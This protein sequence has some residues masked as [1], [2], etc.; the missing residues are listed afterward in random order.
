MSPAMLSFSSSQVGFVNTHTHARL[1]RAV[2]LHKIQ[3]LATV[4]H[5]VMEL[6]LCVRSRLKEIK[7]KS[8]VLIFDLVFPPLLFFFRLQTLLC[9]LR[10]QLN[11][12]FPD[13]K[14]DN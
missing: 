2:S 14:T 9:I 1:S 11:V 10:P 6:H 3:P 13:Q 7:I 12:S 8:K 5:V 4:F